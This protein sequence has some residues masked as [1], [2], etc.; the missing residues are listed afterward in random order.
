MYTNTE[1]AR[2]S[3]TGLAGALEKVRHVGFC[4]QLTWVSQVA[5]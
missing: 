2:E 3:S 5:L 1:V 4:E